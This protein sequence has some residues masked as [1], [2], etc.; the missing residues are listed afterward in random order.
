M[1]IIRWLRISECLADLGYQVDVIADAR[2]PFLSPRAN[3]RVVPGD[4]F[5]WSRYHVIKTLFHR[6]FESLCAAGGAGHPFVISKLG[7]VVGNEDGIAGVHFFGQ[8]RQ[9][10]FETQ[11]RIHRQSRF[12]TVLTNASRRLWEDEFGS[13]QRLLMVPTGV[14][15]QIPPPRRNPY[16]A[17]SERIAVYVGNIY[18]RTQPEVNRL[19]QSRLNDLGRLLR[20]KGIRL[21]LVGPGNTSELDEDAVTYLGPVHHDASWDYQHFAD[22]GIVLTQGP[23]Q[24]NE[25]SKLYYYLRTGLPVV[26]ENP[27][28]N[29]HVL[30]EAELGLLTSYGDPHAMA[31]AVEVA[32]YRDW[33]REQAIRYVVE[34]HTWDRRVELYDRLIRSH[35]PH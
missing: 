27:V 13:A 22:V 33:P 7:S 31:D 9:G 8:E 28:P 14:D 25:S 34:N 32:V 29:N 10:L 17:F 30:E 12:V 3:L 18:T 15:R 19:W 24:H 35:F 11:R 1:D 4:R 2:G 23:V 6:G 5:D 26:S 16:S 21:C 20:K